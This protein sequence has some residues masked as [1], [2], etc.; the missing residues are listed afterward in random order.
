MSYPGNDPN[1]TMEPN[2]RDTG[3]TLI[4]SAGRSWLFQTILISYLSIQNI[5]KHSYIEPI[6]HFPKRN[7]TK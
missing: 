7:C 1:N 5:G 4:K 6:I 2:I 3:H